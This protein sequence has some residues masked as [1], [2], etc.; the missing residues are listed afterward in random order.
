MVPQP[1]ATAAQPCLMLPAQGSGGTQESMRVNMPSIHDSERRR[2]TPCSQRRNRKR[3]VVIGGGIAGLAAC[4]RL[5]QQACAGNLPLDVVLLE[6]S[7]R[8]GGVVATC[9]EDGLLIEEGPDCF[10]AIK[11]EGVELCDELGLGDELIG[12]TTEHRRSFIV[13]QGSLVPVPQGFYLMAPGSLWP[14]VAT[15]AFSWPGK[16]RMALDLVLPRRANLEDDESLADFVT[17]RLGKEALERMAQPM[18]GGIYTAD[19]GRLSMQATM[20]QFLDMERRHRS[21]IL[22][23]RRRQR[24]ADAQQPGVSGARYGLFASFRH[25]M[26]TLVDALADRLSA[27]AV[28]LQTPVHSVRRDPGG[29]HWRISPGDGPDLEADA[30]CLALAAPQAG[31]LLTGLD[32]EL[33]AGLQ[34][35]PYASSA[36][37]TLACDRADFT[38]PLNGMGFVVPAVERR[39]LIACSFSSVKFAGRAPAGKVLLRAFVGG[40]LQQEQALWPD[41]RLQ[42]AVCGDLRQLLGLTA[43]PALVQVQ[44]HP[45]A[46]PQ[47]HV[48]HLARVERLEAAARRWHGLA[49]AGN[50]YHGV[51]VPDCIRSGNNAARGMLSA[52]FPQAGDGIN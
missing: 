32:N 2:Q 16:L 24:Q 20:P 31:R 22:A 37:V 15:R 38:H 7:G 29:R 25:G 11:P 4:Y 3:A 51:G 52:L 21:V 40:A 9:R 30:L 48:G 18:I 36:I 35:I 19:P 44:R 34:D 13:R 8:L 46:M 5:T 39:N 27:S 41:A 1:E 42:D 10:L 49:L 33:A 23:L 47:Y 14:F 28:R 12:T 50:A 26:Q 45:E 17:R 43:K 6:A